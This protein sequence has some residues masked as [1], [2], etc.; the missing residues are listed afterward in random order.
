MSE[1]GEQRAVA[2]P[3]WK[4]GLTLAAIA[5]ICT[6]LVALSY[7]LTRDR[8]AANEQA[9][10]EQS[11]Q[12]AIAGIRYDGD[13][14]S[15]PI[16]L[17][18]P[19]PLPGTRDAIIYRARSGGSVVAALFVVAAA[20][21]F[22]GPIRLLVGVQADGRLTGVRILEHKETPGIGDLIDQSRSNWV[23]QFIGR[24]LQ[25]PTLELWSIRGDGGE[26]DQVTGASIT[27][28]AVIKA[29]KETL[30]YFDEHKGSIL[31]LP[32]AEVEGA[33]Q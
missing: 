17:T 12:P 16:V 28:R 20:D 5:A 6:L 2:P 8:I 1:F 7:N 29:V 33:E 11:L 15:A 31:T 23:E 4:S 25:D 3:I 30:V 21:G 18:P 27:P 13:L 10:L 26:F 22:S 9:H 24:S 32:A 14:S 19:H